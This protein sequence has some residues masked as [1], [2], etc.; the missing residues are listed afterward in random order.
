MF[1]LLYIVADTHWLCVT[2]KKL[3]EPRMHSEYSGSSARIRRQEGGLHVCTSDNERIQGLKALNKMN[4]N[5][6]TLFP[7]L[8]TVRIYSLT[9]AAKIFCVCTFVF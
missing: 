9:P 7:D 6:S 1:S 2:L 4:I 3:K 8:L 5:Y